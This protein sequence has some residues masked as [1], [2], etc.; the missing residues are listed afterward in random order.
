ML[1]SIP[2]GPDT[3]W[4]ITDP[5]PSLEGAIR[6]LRTQWGCQR[7]LIEAGPSSTR[8]AYERWM[9]EWEK[10][11]QRAS[12][13]LL[14]QPS[15]PVDLLFLTILR[16]P[17]RK[18]LLGPEFLPSRIGRWKAPSGRAMLDAW[19]EPPEWAVQ[20]HYCDEHT[21]LGSWE[22]R[23]LRPRMHAPMDLWSWHARSPREYV[24][25][26]TEPRDAEFPH[27]VARI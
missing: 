19:M 23:I 26:H 24:E 10:F 12:T 15:P 4:V 16:G 27:E 3:R 17:L 2:S 6:R 7:V 1:L 20:P 5:E 11:A 9:G 8:P 25:D 22:F 14:F 13:D 21:A 18:E